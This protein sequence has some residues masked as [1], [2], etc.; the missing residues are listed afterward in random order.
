MQMKEQDKTSEKGLNRVETSN[1]LDKEFKVV[2]IRMLSEL[3]KRR[4]DEHSNNLNKEA[5]NIEKSHTK[6]KNI[7]TEVK[8]ALGGTSRILHD[9]EEWISKLEDSAAVITLVEQ[10]KF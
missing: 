10:K 7:M 8:S 4:M 1:W 3:Q 2:I 6:W 5:E 9:T